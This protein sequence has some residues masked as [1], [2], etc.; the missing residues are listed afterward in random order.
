MATTFSRVPLGGGG[1]VTDIRISADGTTRLIKTDVSPGGYVWSTANNPSG[2]WESLITATSM[3]GTG[4]VQGNWGAGYNC[5]DVAFAPGNPSIIYMIA[6]GHA[7]AGNDSF[8]FRSTDRGVTFSLCAIDG[9]TAHSQGDNYRAFGYKSDVNP[10]DE[11]DLIWTQN[12]GS[13]WRTLDGG[14]TAVQ[15]STSDIPLGYP[16]CVA[17]D[18]NSS[19]VIYA[20]SYN[21]GLYRTANGGTS[22]TKLSGSGTAATGLTLGRRMIVD[23]FG[24]VWITEASTVNNLWRYNGSVTN[25]TAAAGFEWGGVATNPF[26]SSLGANQITVQSDGGNIN[27][28][29]DN[30]ATWTDA[31]PVEGIR[32]ATD[33]AWM[34]DCEEDFLTASNCAYDPIVSNRLWCGAGIGVWYTTPQNNANQPTWTELTRGND[35]LIAQHIVKPPGG[36]RKCIV[37]VQDRGLFAVDGTNYPTRQ[38]HNRSTA[39]RHGGSI[40]Y[41]TADPDF[42]V[43]VISGGVSGEVVSKQHSGWSDDNGA[44]FTEFVAQPEATQWGG[45]VCVSATD[46]DNILYIPCASG[47]VKYSTDRG[48]TWTASAFGGIAGATTPNP[49]SYAGKQ[50]IACSDKTTGGTFYIYNV[51]TSD[52][53]GGLWRSTDSGANFTR[54]VVEWAVSEAGA[55]SKLSSVPGHAGHLCWSYGASGPNPYNPTGTEYPTIFRRSTDGGAN[56]TN[57]GDGWWEVHSHGFGKEAPGETYPAIY[58]SGARV[59]DD[60]GIYVSTDEFAT[61]TRLGEDYATYDYLGTLDGDMDVYGDVWVG[62]TSSG[63]VKGS[64]NSS[65]IRLKW[66]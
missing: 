31:Y 22:W 63:V 45:V 52:T 53:S 9:F 30:G 38:I 32:V 2:Q 44:T 36:S 55:G 35:E 4:F 33:I 41:C 59:G 50:I 11:D 64:I 58:V 29:F 43:G 15:I 40:D 5:H 47:P 18:P 12:D 13:F 8:L 17:F 19:G 51:K 61:W 49:A 27:H 28:S 24:Q 65:L 60:P 1:L 3:A 21:T 46:P 54:Q 56:W 34:A 6:P 14:A 39:I 57:L 26:S 66:A 37:S 23:K 25:I 7:G 20:F 48:D 10:F 62:L 42:F 16:N